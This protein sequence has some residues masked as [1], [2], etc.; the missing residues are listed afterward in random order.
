LRAAIAPG[1]RAVILARGAK[2]VGKADM[3]PTESP[4]K[5]RRIIRVILLIALGVFIGLTVQR[6]LRMIRHEVTLELFLAQEMT[7]KLTSLEMLVREPDRGEEALAFVQ[8]RPPGA[9]EPRKTWVHTL[10]LP[11]GTYQLEFFLQA[12]G[13]I[14]VRALRSLEVSGSESVRIHLP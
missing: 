6:G 2:G 11:R 3:E 14:P 7:Q 13:T 4:K 8:F 5:K 1:L 12:S 10:S 9:G